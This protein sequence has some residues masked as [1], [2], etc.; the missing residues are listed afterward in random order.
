MAG[1]NTIE[2]RYA[3][4]KDSTGKVI[5]QR[6]Q[7]RTRDTLITVLGVSLATW[8]DWRDIEADVVEV[9]V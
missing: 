1:S 3:I 2:F 4:K 8:S 5:D 6:L 7:F 9:I